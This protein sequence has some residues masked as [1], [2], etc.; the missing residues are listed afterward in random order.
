MK[1]VCLLTYIKLKLFS[2]FICTVPY[3]IYFTSQRSFLTFVLLQCTI[4]T[5]YAYRFYKVLIRN[6]FLVG[7]LSFL[8][9]VGK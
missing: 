5:D 9:T 7:L 6:G 1:K 8:I 4:G 3:D 2:E